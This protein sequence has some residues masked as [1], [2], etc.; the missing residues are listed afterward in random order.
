MDCTDRAFHPRAPTRHVAGSSALSAA[1]CRSRRLFA[2]WPRKFADGFIPIPLPSFPWNRQLAEVVISERPI[3][4]MIR[5]L[6]VVSVRFWP[7][8]S[9]KYCFGF[10]ILAFS[11]FGISSET[12]FSGRHREFWPKETVWAERNLFQPLIFDW[13]KLPKQAISAERG[14]FVLD[15]CF[16]WKI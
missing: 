10:G 16:G 5:F 11:S 8:Y 4:K 3:P 9:A 1:H 2:R 6:S 14:C 13:N 12:H 15:K 7:K